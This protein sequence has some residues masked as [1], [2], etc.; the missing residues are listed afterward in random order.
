MLFESGIPAWK[1]KNLP[2]ALQ[3]EI[4]TLADAQRRDVQQ[5]VSEAEVKKEK[6]FH[7]EHSGTL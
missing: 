2:I 5:Q 7:F 6:A 1:T 3:M 4:E